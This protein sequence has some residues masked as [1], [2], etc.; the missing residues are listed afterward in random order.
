MKL[1]KYF[2]LSVLIP[3]SSYSQNLIPNPGFESSLDGWNTFWARTTNAGMAEIVTSPTHSGSKA[4]H[5]KHWGAED[6]SFS[7]KSLLMVKT[8][9]YYEFSAYVKVN[10]QQGWGNISVILYDS[11]KNVLNWSYGT[12]AFDTLSKEY[13]K[14]TGKFLIPQNV[15]Y[16]NPRIIG[17]GIGELYI[18]DLELLLKDSSNG[19]NK[20]F[21]MGNNNISVSITLPGFSID[22]TDK[23]NMKKYALQPTYNF[24]CSH[25][26]SAKNSF[27]FYCQYIP[28]NFDAQ[29]QFTLREK[30]IKIFLSADS[31]APMS[32]SIS[33][34]GII[35]S[36][37][38]QKLIIPRGTGIIL[39]VEKANPFG[40]F[41]FYAWKST[42]AFTGVTDLQTGYLL[43]SD[44]PW[45]T[46]VRFV[47]SG[48]DTLLSPQMIHTDSK[49]KFSHNRTF[50]FTPISSN[51][52]LEMCTWYRN[53]VKELGYIKT[54]QSK[55]AQNPNMERLKGAVDFWALDKNFQTKIFIDSMINY[56]M[57]KAII[58]LS[59]S[60]YTSADLSKIID[61]INSRGLLSSRYD[62][63]T[64]VW[65]PTHPEWTGYR[66]DGYPDDIIV[67]KSG[68]LQTGWLAYINGTPFQGYVCC[69]LEH[70]KYAQKW[71]PS[72]LSK[73]GYNCR[74][75]DVECAASLY[76]CY[77]TVHPCGRK[78]DAKARVE[79][80][81][82]IKNKFDLV[83]GSEEA[84][85]FAFPVVDYGEG[86][87]TIRP[88]NNAGYD[89]STP[90]DTP[91]SEYGDQ[92]DPAIRVPLHGLV[93]H[94][95]HVPTWYTG[96]GASKV[97]AYWDDKD[98]LNILYS[99]MPLFLPPNYKY[100][101]ANKEKFIT[102]Y[103]LVSSVFRE[104]GFEEMTGHKFLTSNN[105][106]QQTT[107]FN[108][109][110]VTANFDNSN[111]SFEGITLPSKGFYASNGTNEVYRIAENGN[112]VAAAKLTDRIF[113]NP[114]GVE[115]TKYGLR[116]SGLLFLKKNDINIHLAFLG[117]QSYIDI[118]P[119]QLPW[120]ISNIKVFVKDTT[121]EIIPVKLS[122]GWL[123]INKFS[124]K[125]FYTLTF[126]AVQTSVTETIPYKFDLSA[127]PNPFNPSTNIKY[128]IPTKQL[129]KIEIYNSLGQL[130]AIPVNKEQDSGVYSFSFGNSNLASGMYIVNI[131]AGNKIKTVKLMMVK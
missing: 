84:R 42:M 107:F 5:I 43:T 76:E 58:S 38:G 23:S 47:K 90:I 121:I 103:H 48:T 96:D 116:S 61:T 70:T 68:G 21:S 114:Y 127:F 40:D 60:W 35:S 109:W 4:L 99:S 69:S 82:M 56:G 28:D 91:E 128:S 31:T 124:N 36:A 131:Q 32:S 93:Y 89:W 6:W 104:T 66:T 24:K 25:V 117:S 63:Y 122:G 14:Y 39:P 88:V 125:I 111:Y 123:R 81:D 55:L 49:G 101:L 26:D 15:K 92:N 34:P 71:L 1:F 16:I 83:T 29:L 19:T 72:E 87:M 17:G 67:T 78:E 77:S 126:S 94:D 45:N 105:K 12:A 129:V 3:F 75:I 27:V 11:L 113:L 33:F 65:P 51:G 46:I 64:D 95:V 119:D 37:I 120:K 80:L 54:F 20:I 106:V 108:G 98:L 59:G 41:Y 102:S 79:L 10:E 7:S 62:I 30:D 50:Y 73:Y 115:S 9:N 57:D 112:T 130:V 8:G 118:N 97:P 22:I 86:T 85:E 110:K 53:H 44:D 100:W 52:Y 13:V 18:D 74:F 2:L